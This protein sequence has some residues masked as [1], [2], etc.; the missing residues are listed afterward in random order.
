MTM[1]E[2]V[3]IPGPVPLP[4]IGNLLNINLKSTLQSFRES[5]SV[6]FPIIIG[7]LVDS[8][9][10]PLYDKELLDYLLRHTTNFGLSRFCWNL[11]TN[12]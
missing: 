11:W 3:P 6:L 12:L 9:G 7:P 1:T 4:I 10:T 8:C 2:N 5:H